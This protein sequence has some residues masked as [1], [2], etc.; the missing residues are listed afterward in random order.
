MVISLFKQAFAIFENIDRESNKIDLYII[1]K[2]RKKLGLPMTVSLR[3]KTN[4]FKMICYSLGK[5]SALGLNAN[6]FD[7]RSVHLPMAVAYQVGF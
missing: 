6:H 1:I 7:N 3:L 4:F 2:C 5:N